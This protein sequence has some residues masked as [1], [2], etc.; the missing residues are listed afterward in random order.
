MIK[1]YIDAA[2]NQSKELSAGGMIIVQDKQQKQL[3]YSLQ[4]K[5]NNEAEF[6]ML[7]LAL[8]YCME[9]AF[10]NSMIFIY[11]DSK[12]VTE[13][14]RK[15]HA[16]DERFKIF[17]TPILDLLPKFPMLFIEW[18]GEKDNKGA[19]NLARQAL[20]KRYSN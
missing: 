2:T 14:I 15:K 19:D 17:L 13:S 9:Q 4:S 1:I 6:E 16:K 12:I 18:V 10:H 20:Q 3:H 8:T 7:Q 11:T 5:T